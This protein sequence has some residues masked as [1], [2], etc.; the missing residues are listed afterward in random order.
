MAPGNEVTEAGEGEG[1][2]KAGIEAGKELCR[3]A[4]DELQTDSQAHH[5]NDEDITVEVEEGKERFLAFGEVEDAGGVT[6]DE[7]IEHQRE[8]DGYGEGDQT[9]PPC[10]V[11]MR[12]VDQE[13]RLNAGNEDFYA[14]TEPSE[15]LHEK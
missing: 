4:W 13:E 9:Q 2:T 15:Q 12:G 11:G 7:I 3:H 14:W 6:L 8:R 1:E 5:K 10:A